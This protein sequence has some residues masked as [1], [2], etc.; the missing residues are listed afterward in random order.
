MVKFSKFQASLVKLSGTASV[1]V[2]INEIVN[3][4]NENVQ[5]MRLDRH[6]IAF[7]FSNE[8]L[9]ELGSYVF[10]SVF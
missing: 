2:L 6:F 3:Y 4:V 7:P 1:D 10:I 5:K 8:F 9:W